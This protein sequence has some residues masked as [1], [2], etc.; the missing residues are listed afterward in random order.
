MLRSLVGSEM[1]IRDSPIVDQS[2]LH[3]H[4]ESSQD[5][6]SQK[7]KFA[8]VL[9]VYADVIEFLDSPTSPNVWDREMLNVCG[10]AIVFAGKP[11]EKLR[12]RLLRMYSNDASVVQLLGGAMEPEAHQEVAMAQSFMAPPPPVTTKGGR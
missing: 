7:E 10:P 3:P 5:T 1:C 8:A 11:L 2:L 9:C 6:A 12:R 4:L